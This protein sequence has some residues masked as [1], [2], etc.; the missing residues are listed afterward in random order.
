MYCKKRLGQK[1]CVGSSPK[2]SA[3]EIVAI[4]MDALQNNKK[5]KH[6]DGIKL[7]YR[8]ASP[9]NKRQTGPLD[10]FTKMIQGSVYHHLLNCLKWNFVKGSETRTPD[11]LQYSVLVYV[12]SSVDDKRY[13]YRF[14][15]SRQYD[16]QH[17][18]P[19]Y[20]E[21]HKTKLYLY[22]RT[23][24]V[25]LVK[26]GGSL[27]ENFTSRGDLNIYDQPLT[28]CSLDPMTGWRRDGKCSTDSADHG[29]HT[30]CATLN[31]KFLDFTKSKGNDLS[32]QRGSFPGLKPGDK[33]CLCA[34][35]YK[36]AYDA[37]IKL[38]V[39]RRATGK[40]TLDYVDKH[41]LS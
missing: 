17:D 3:E 2:M 16:F 28:T 5:N 12:K 24:S 32:S 8:L 1:Y 37:G 27:L 33:W 18:Q 36:E 4:Q 29:T 30:V 13:I 35:R 15:L 34:M 25:N 40:K 26:K 41:Q 10:S 9:A 31:Q 22:W 19:L 14:S 39:D 20:D 7:A 38:P 6:N 11:D 23:D 21:F